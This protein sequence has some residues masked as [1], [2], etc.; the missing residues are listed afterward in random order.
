ML[1]AGQYLCIVYDSHGRGLASSKGDFV[2]VKPNRPKE[3][4]E[5]LSL[6]FTAVWVAPDAVLKRLH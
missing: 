3:C 5:F 2:S 6:G 1:G 4:K